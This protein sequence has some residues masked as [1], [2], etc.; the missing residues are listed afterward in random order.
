MMNWQ[1]DNLN[2]VLIRGL[3]DKWKD[4]L[5]SCVE[6]NKKLEVDPLFDRLSKG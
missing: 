3:L 2:N 6:E 4:G 1:V 5:A